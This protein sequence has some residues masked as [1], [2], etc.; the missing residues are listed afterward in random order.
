M[1]FGLRGDEVLAS[2]RIG[3]HRLEVVMRPAVVWIALSL[4]LLFVGVTLAQVGTAKTG[5]AQATSSGDQIRAFGVFDARA[6]GVTQTRDGLKVFKG[7]VAI[8]VSDSVRVT[9]EADEA[10]FNEAT[11]ELVATGTI[12]IKALPTR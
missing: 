12:R 7:H 4:C 1:S 2:R 3:I 11:H 5:P 9:I 8:A 10:T 6:D